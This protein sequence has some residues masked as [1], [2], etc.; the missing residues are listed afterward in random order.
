MQIEVIERSQ[1]RRWEGPLRRA[2]ALRH[3]V[4]VDSYGW[5]F[6]RRPDG[7]DVD[8]HDT[9]EAT[10]VLALDGETVGG[11]IRLIPGGYLVVSRANPALLRQA[12]GNAA[13]FGLSRLCVDPAIGRRDMILFWLAAAAFERAL[14]FGAGALLFDTD[15]RMVLLMRLLGLPAVTVGEAVPAGERMM[16]PVVL[17]LAP[18]IT[19]TLRRNLTNRRLKPVPA[20]VLCFAT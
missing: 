7:L 4:F 17:R 1:R 6:L 18:S 8:Q 5:E 14:E 19:E 2:F 15:P 12:A 3:Q 9:G 20:E 10:H 11:H 13:L 16:Q